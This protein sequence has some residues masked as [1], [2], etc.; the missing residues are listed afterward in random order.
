VLTGDYFTAEA[1]YG[2][3]FKAAGIGA[4]AVMR[5]VGTVVLPTEVVAGAVRELLEGEY[6]IAA[7]EGY[8]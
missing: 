7:P 5:E 8:R 4:G 3:V 2:L 1:L 6:G